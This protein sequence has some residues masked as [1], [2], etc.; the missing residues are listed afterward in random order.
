MD[1]QCFWIRNALKIKQ[2][3][4]VF[5]DLLERSKH[6]DNTS[7]RPCMN[8]SPKTL[9]FEGPAPTLRFG[10]S[11]DS[12]DENE[13]SSFSLE[14]VYDRLILRTHPTTIMNKP[15]FL[16]NSSAIAIRSESFATELP[17]KYFL[18][19]LITVMIPMD[20]WFY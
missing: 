3:I 11:R 6:V 7:K 17:K 12:D 1:R 16:H 20:G 8:P 19:I 15:A 9:L 10:K 4:E 13:S 18:I 2:Q 14:S 5:R